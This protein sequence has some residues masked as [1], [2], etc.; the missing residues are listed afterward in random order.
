MD[1]NVGK[2]INIGL[3]HLFRIIIIEP[4]FAGGGGGGQVVVKLI[5]T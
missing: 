4:C 2:N 1:A 5:G 3:N